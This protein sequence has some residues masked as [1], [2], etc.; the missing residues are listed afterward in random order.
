[1]NKGFHIKLYSFLKIIHRFSNYLQK[2]SFTKCKNGDVLNLISRLQ[3]IK[4]VLGDANDLGM[5]W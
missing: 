4:K 2:S 5:S 1:M 3:D